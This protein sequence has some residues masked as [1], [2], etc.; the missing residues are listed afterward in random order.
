M[1]HGLLVCDTVSRHEIIELGNVEVIDE[2]HKKGFSGM[3]IR[4]RF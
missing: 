4:M 3:G 1:K 2:L